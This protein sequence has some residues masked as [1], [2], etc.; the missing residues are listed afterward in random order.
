V[1]VVTEGEPERGSG[2]RARGELRSALVAESFGLLSERGLAGFS[3]A[4]LARR[5][6]VS[7]AA[8]YRHFQNREK[9]LAVVATQAASELTEAMRAAADAAGPD[10]VD[11]LAGTA[12]A[13]VR[14][15]SA[16]GVGF[17]VIFARELRS[18][19]DD[20]LAE[21][22]RGLMTLLLD[23]AQ[24]TRQVEPVEALR[25]VEQVIA[26]AHGYAALDPGDFLTSVQLFDD[27]VATRATRAAAALVR[28][29]PVPE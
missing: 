3:V 19:R 8:P 9:L 2:R 6:G 27:D 14:F 10:P 12:G 21:A 1:V 22:G 25:L 15:A 29:R 5:L 20:A 4:E 28:G 23:L 18:L 24:S 16:R 7:T 13:Y 17:D 26:L 11:R